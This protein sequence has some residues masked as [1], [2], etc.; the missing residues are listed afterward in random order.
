MKIRWTFYIFW[1]QSGRVDLEIPW[2]IKSDRYHAA[3]TDHREKNISGF[4]EISLNSEPQVDYLMNQYYYPRSLTDSLIGDRMQLGY[5]LSTYKKSNNHRRFFWQGY[6]IDRTVNVNDYRGLA[7]FEEF[8]RE[9]VMDL[10]VVKTGGKKQLNIYNSFE[11]NFSSPYMVVLNNQI[12]IDSHQL[13]NIP[14]SDIKS[15]KMIYLKESLKRLGKTITNGVVIVETKKDE[16]IPERFLE[17]K[18]GYI[19]RF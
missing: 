18:A 7:N 14:L 19:G 12:L 13:F 2:P 17:S 6:T 16:A 8:V 9:A 4:Y 10:S 15:V 5:I 11:G 1:D 3:I